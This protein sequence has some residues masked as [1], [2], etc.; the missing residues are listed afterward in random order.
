[1]SSLVRANQ[2]PYKF[3]PRSRFVIAQKIIAALA[4]AFF[5]A[6]FVAHLPAARDPVGPAPL[7]QAR[8]L[9]AAALAAVGA[10]V[11]EAADLEPSA[12]FLAGPVRALHPFALRRPGARPADAIRQADVREVGPAQLRPS[13]PAYRTVSVHRYPVAD[14]VEAQ[15]AVDVAPHPVVA[16]ADHA[17]P[18]V[19]MGRFPN[20]MMVL[21]SL[22][23]PVRLPRWAYAIA[24]LPDPGLCRL[25]AAWVTDLRAVP[26]AE[27]SR[28]GELVRLVCHLQTAK[29][30]HVLRLAQASRLLQVVAALRPCLFHVQPAPVNRLTRGPVSHPALHDPLCRLEEAHLPDRD[31]HPLDL[32]LDPAP[33]CP[34][35]ER[36]HELAVVCSSDFRL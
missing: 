15:S 24:H 4:V 17:A 16:L 11:A 12:F 6:V 30:L 27:V 26:M 31:P 32:S 25:L 5:L 18:V 19:A 7:R 3:P 2:T 35:R 20:L 9:A 14:F 22:L 28:R 33:G 29:A 13:V 10:V 36:Q 34:P 21:L 1:M 23:L 8:H